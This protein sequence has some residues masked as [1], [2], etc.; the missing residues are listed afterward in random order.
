M[1][2]RVGTDAGRPQ[3]RRA[4]LRILRGVLCQRVPPS[5]EPRMPLNL[6]AADVIVRETLAHARAAAASCRWRSSSSTSAAW[7]SPPPSEDGTSLGRFEIAHGKALRRA[8]LQSRLAELGEMAVERPHFFAGAAH[9]VGGS[10][11]SPVASSSRTRAV[12]CSAR[13][14]FRAT[15]PTMTR[16]RRS[17]GSPRRASS[18]TAA[19]GKSDDAGLPGGND[20]ATITYL[21][22]IE[23]GAGVV[24]DL[25]DAARARS[26]CRGRSS[27][28][29]AGWSG[30]ASSRASP[31][32]CPAGAPVFLDV[33]P[34]PTEAAALAALAVYRDDGCDGVVALGGGS[35]IDLAK[36]VALLATHAGAARDLR[37]DLWRHR[38]RSRAAVAP[39]IAIPTTAGTGSEVGRAG[40]DHARRRPQAR[41]HQP[42]P[43]PEARDLRSRADARP[44]AGADRRDRARRAVALHRDVPV[45]ALQSAGRGDRARRRGAHLA[46]HRAGRARRAAISPRGPR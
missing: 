18:A 9:A 17:P 13:S 27:S 26:A 33:P 38:R 25:A 32:L 24:A 34:N 43:H 37:R 7:W 1:A 36:G 8:R 11:R 40:A 29:T 19:D 2:A 41:L 10:S 46:Q 6:A 16:P 3:G 22:T 20:M 44:A 30:P 15:P 42:A 21:T 28:A 12:R 45:A 14:A 35:P 31:A 5:R 23:F 39:V 4:L